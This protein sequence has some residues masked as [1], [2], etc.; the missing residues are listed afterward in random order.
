LQRLFSFDIFLLTL[1]S[2]KGGIIW[3]GIQVI[4]LLLTAM[5][6]YLTPNIMSS[7]MKNKTSMEERGLSYW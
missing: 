2:K 7:K 6:M 5:S 3:A 1:V 4:V